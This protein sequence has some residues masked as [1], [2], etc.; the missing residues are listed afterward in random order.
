MKFLDHYLRKILMSITNH[1][2][3]STTTKKILASLYVR[4]LL[5]FL[6]FYMNNFLKK[7]KINIF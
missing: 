4:V 5:I 1:Q 7:D 2:L 6:Y 3:V